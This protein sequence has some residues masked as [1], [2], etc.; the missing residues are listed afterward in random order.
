MIIRRVVIPLVAAYALFVFMAL[1]SLRAPPV[2]R[3]DVERVT[4]WKEALHG[5]AVT[6]AGGYLCFLL[7]VLV[8]HVLIAGQ[9]GALVSA[10]AGGGF[11]AFGVATPVFLLSLWRSS[12]R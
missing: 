6:V 7:I 3:A 2:E 4:G 11:L 9:R 8:F 10:A 1:S 5:L 12:R